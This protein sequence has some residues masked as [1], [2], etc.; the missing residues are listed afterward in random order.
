MKNE[1]RPIHVTLSN[2]SISYRVRKP[3]PLSPVEAR[4]DVEGALSSQG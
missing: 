4:R 3:L 2:G 1:C